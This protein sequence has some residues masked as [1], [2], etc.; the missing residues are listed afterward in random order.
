MTLQ[1][2][3]Q[4]LGGVADPVGGNGRVVR[5]LLDEEET[6]AASV[7]VRPVSA[8]DPT[9]DDDEQPWRAAE[10]RGRTFRDGLVMAKYLEN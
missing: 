7:L 8:E 1:P 10:K 2:E 4:T 3:S 9:R 6:I 5:D